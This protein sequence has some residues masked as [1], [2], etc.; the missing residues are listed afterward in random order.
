L[1]LHIFPAQQASP[2]LP[3]A[4]SADASD[5]PSPLSSRLASVPPSPGDAAVHN[6]LMHVSP[7]SH[8]AALQQA[9]PGPPQGATQTPDA[10]VKPLSQVVPLQHG[11]PEAPQAAVPSGPASLRGEVDPPHLAT[12][13]AKQKHAHR[14][15]NLRVTCPPHLTSQ[16]YS[17][18]PDSA[19]CSASSRACSDSYGL[20]PI[21]PCGKAQRLHVGTV[22]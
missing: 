6:P 5:E 9:C 14:S 8:T 17:F 18:A 12:S 1:P 16:A 22:H 10:Q 20:R 11:S 3:H 4:P 15:P 7:L 13:N 19:A 21:K 2:V